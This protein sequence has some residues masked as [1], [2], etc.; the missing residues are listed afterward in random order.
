[1]SCE[2]EQWVKSPKVDPSVK[3]VTHSKELKFSS[4][5]FSFLFAR[6]SRKFAL[7]T[8]NSIYSAVQS[9]LPHSHSGTSILSVLKI[10][11]TKRFK[12]FKLLYLKLCCTYNTTI[13]EVIS[14]DTADWQYVSG[15]KARGKAIPEEIAEEIIKN[16]R[17]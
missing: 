8:T 6:F 9:I 11:T 1:M 4:N 5:L 10:S 3:R 15:A 2:A 16:S 13:L 12:D 14:E 7:E 17:N